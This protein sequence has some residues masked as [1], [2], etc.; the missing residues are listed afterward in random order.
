MKHVLITMS[1][2]D[3][4]ALTAKKDAFTWLELLKRAVG[5]PTPKFVT[6]AMVEELIDLKLSKLKRGY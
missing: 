4:I 6:L 1:D 2:A 5:L 3:Y